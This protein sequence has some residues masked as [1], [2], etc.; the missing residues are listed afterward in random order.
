GRLRRVL[1]ACLGLTCAA[2]VVT[3]HDPWTFERLRVRE[4]DLILYDVRVDQPQA[5]DHVQG[6]AVRSGRL[7][8]IRND[9]V[10]GID[11]ERIAFPV[12]YGMTGIA[13]AG[14]VRIPRVRML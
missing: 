13:R 11:D 2:A 6:A 14:S 4:G 8:E 9:H 3:R 10:D 1:G 7:V 5:L 12:A